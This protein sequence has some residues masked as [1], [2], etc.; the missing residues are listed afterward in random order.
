MS[1]GQK[2]FVGVMLCLVAVSV[3]PDRFYYPMEHMLERGTMLLVFGAVVGVPLAM[4]VLGVSTRRRRTEAV[5]ETRAAWRQ[6]PVKLVFMTAFMLSF[7]LFFGGLFL[8]AVGWEPEFPF[9]EV[10]AW[11]V[12][13]WGTLFLV[14]VGWLTGWI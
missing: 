14:A 6:S 3:L 1:F 8:G 4:L 11:I 13:M 5:E 7:F 12:G 10:R 9:T 2:V